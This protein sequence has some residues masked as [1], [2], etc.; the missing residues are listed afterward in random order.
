MAVDSGP[1]DPVREGV[2]DAVEILGHSGR[3]QNQPIIK[4]PLRVVQV[5]IPLPLRAE[6]KFA[7]AVGYCERRQW[8]ISVLLAIAISER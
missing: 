8:I 2:P 5:V 1:E 3:L 7:E 6:R 4:R